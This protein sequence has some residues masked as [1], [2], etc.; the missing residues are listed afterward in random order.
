MNERPTQRPDILLIDPPFGLLSNPYISIP[1]LGAWLQ[2]S[3]FEVQALDMSSHFY[4]T[5]LNPANVQAGLTHM[6]QRLH[7]LNNRPQLSF[8][9]LREL[10][11]LVSLHLAR[12]IPEVSE[13]L[14]RFFMPYGGYPVLQQTAMRDFFI[15]AATIPF[16]PHHINPRL[17]PAGAAQEYFSTTQLIRQAHEGTPY[18]PTFHQILEERLDTD[19]PPP[20]IGFSVA[21][22]NQIPTAF[23]CAAI[24]RKLLPSAHITMGGACISIF[25]RELKNPDIFDLVD[26]IVL[27]DGERPLQTLCEMG[28]NGSL[29][30]S[31]V[32]G[33]LYREDGVIH[34][35]PAPA[36]IDMEK[37]PA[38]DYSLYDLDDYLVA[39]TALHVPYR[40][41]KGCQWQK[42]T[43]CRTDLP[44]C[45]DFQS[46]DPEIMYQGLRQTIEQSGI[47]KVIFSDESSD[48]AT[49][50][51]VS[52]WL[53]RD[54]VDLEWQCHTRV[55]D[56][57]THDR[58]KLFRQAGCRHLALGIESMCDQTLR[59]MGKGINAGLVDSVLR[60]ISGAVPIHA[61]MIVG[62]P[63]E[64]REEALRGFDQIKAYHE[65]GLIAS[66]AYSIFTLSSGSAIHRNPAAFGLTG[67]LT[68]PECD[69]P[70]DLIVME[71]DR[72]PEEE[73]FKLAL[74]FNRAFME[75]P[76]NRKV[77]DCRTVPTA[78]AD[79]PLRFSLAEHQEMLRLCQFPSFSKLPSV[80]AARERTI[81][82]KPPSAPPP[83]GPI[84][85]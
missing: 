67:T 72:I 29:D 30:L 47:C 16:Y 45:R 64:T 38:P 5:F 14:T 2:K 85:S 35:T 56:Q 75:T 24:V 21:F 74:D 70:V 69:L 61:Y 17:L 82:A 7:E 25:F 59:R 63:G 53:I 49:L 27:D 22:Q 68:E 44:F 6:T 20:I 48:P 84:C 54:R 50:E 83:E 9:E 33:I 31:A 13:V 40:L 32:P 55:S 41:A 10:F 12:K 26:S 4:R 79:V 58:C 8:D 77:L 34:H 71:G 36:P 23:Q 19:G 3:G 46:A 52:K 62:F 78:D 66:Y 1:L 39:R 43:F 80:R 18:T 28:R 81:S 65:Q 60:E 42:C 57:L 37:A 76:L 15:R 11:H 51:Q 73:L